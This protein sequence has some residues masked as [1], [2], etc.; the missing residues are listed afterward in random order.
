MKDK[1]QKPWSMMLNRHPLL[2]V[3]LLGIVAIFNMQ[4]LLAQRPSEGKVLMAIFAHPD[5]EMTVGPLLV[6]YV[7]EGAKVYLV[8]CTD[9]RYGTNDFS[10]L[11]GGDSLVKIRRAEM[12]CAAD[13]LGATLIH[14][15]FHDQLR[16]GEGYDGHMPH[17]KSL[18]AEL[19][20]IISDKKPDVLVTWGPDG[21]STHMDHRLVGASVNQIF[22][23]KVWEKPSKLFFVG[24]PADQ[25]EDPAQKLLAGVDPKYLNVHVAYSEEDLDKAM[26]S[27]ACHKSQIRPEDIESIKEQRQNS[28]L[29]IHL[30]EFVGP[31]ITRTSVFE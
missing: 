12:Q 11:E 26:N 23:S 24:T 31:E 29:Q 7:D 21:G 3:M 28:G 9:G 25:M 4:P 17:V 10:G 20:K 15:D 19:E 13:A 30:R 8:V 22:V 16:A 2:I 27:L 5:D 18:I 6:K 14:L 1:I